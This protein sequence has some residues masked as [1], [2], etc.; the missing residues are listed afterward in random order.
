MADNYLE[1]KYEQMQQGR[2]VIKKVNRSLD[3]LLTALSEV[4]EKT[5]GQYMVSRLQAGAAIASAR[6]MGIRF[7]AR[8]P[9]EDDPSVM[10]ISCS[11][12]YDLGAV[13]TA[14]RLKFAELHLHTKLRL[15]N[16]GTD[17]VIE[18][19]RRASV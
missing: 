5:D 12:A 9:D 4:P 6:R 19:F 17:A 14:V 15:S 1:K 11:S 16:S 18:I 10:E 3:S 7:S 2:P 13:V 8:F